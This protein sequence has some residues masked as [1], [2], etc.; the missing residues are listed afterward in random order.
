MKLWLTMAMLSLVP[1]LAH[2]QVLGDS[3]TSADADRFDSVRVRGGAFLR[4]DSP[5]RRTT[6]PRDSPSPSGI[7]MASPAFR[8]SCP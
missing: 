3:S 5:A 2:A 7:G 1:A 4:Y 6:A 8:W